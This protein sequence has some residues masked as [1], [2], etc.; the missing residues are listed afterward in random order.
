MLNIVEKLLFCIQ[1]SW[2]LTLDGA[3][4]V[5]KIDNNQG[6]DP[7]LLL[8]SLTHLGKLHILLCLSSANYKG[9]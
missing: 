6:L 4:V 5:V 7:A 8:S 3:V 1:E 2:A 9:R